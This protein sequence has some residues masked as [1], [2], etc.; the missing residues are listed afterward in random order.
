MKIHTHVSCRGGTRRGPSRLIGALGPLGASNTKFTKGEAAHLPTHLCVGYRAARRT[1]SVDD[2]RTTAQSQV[3]NGHH[4]H[5]DFDPDDMPDMSEMQRLLEE[6]DAQFRSIKRGEVVEGQIVRIDP[7]EILV[8][9][10]LKSEG[11]LTTKEL[12]PSGLRLA[13]RA[14]CGRRCARLYHAA[15]DA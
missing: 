2:D 6:Q 10:G 7:E 12:P 13:L 15:R 8:D 11:V 5:P 1:M 14:S 9:I 3:Q 4:P